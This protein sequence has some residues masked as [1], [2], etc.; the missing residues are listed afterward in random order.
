MSQNSPG[1][2][3][4]PPSRT[5]RQRGAIAAALEGQAAFLT[6]QELFELLKSRSAKVGLATIYRNLQAMVER[7]E[8]DVIRRADGEAMY[9]RCNRDEHHHHL[10]CKGCG[11]SIEIDN[12]E[13]ESWAAKIARRHGFTSVTHDLELFGLCEACASRS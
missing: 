13:L 3:A 11:R 4:A 5:T 12:P 1:N 7:G 9:R 2:G 6:A 8:L 10:V